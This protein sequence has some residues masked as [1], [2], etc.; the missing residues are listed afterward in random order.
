M[1]KKCE[2]LKVSWCCCLIVVVVIIV[3]CGGAGG[4]GDDL[5]AI[6]ENI[7]GVCFSMTT[8]QRKKK[9]LKLWSL[10]D[11][12][13]VVNVVIVVA[14]LENI[15]GERLLMT[16]A[17]WKKKFQTLKFSWCCCQCCQC[18]WWLWCCYFRKY[19]CKFF[20]GNSTMEKRFETLK[21]SWCRCYQCC[22]WWC[23]CYI[24]KYWWC[25]FFNY[26]STMEKKNLKLWSLADAV[27]AAVVLGDFVAILENIDGVSF[28]MTTALW[29]KKCEILKFTWCCCCQC[30][31]CWFCCYLKNIDGVSFSMTIAWRKK[32]F[33]N[34]EI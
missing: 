32:M 20:N 22:S 27:V 4:G 11:A 15:D 34:F 16:Q 8:A 3:V 13:V 23:F 9:N 12:V 28:S 10:A 17:P 14:I 5:V 25:K 29:R 6:L 18:C 1:E 24:R 21:F 26:N 19:W 2:I 7:D 30:C 33:W 31:W